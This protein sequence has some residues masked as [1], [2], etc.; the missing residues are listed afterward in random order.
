MEHIRNQQQ[1]QQAHL[2]PP[3]ILLQQ[4][5]QLHQM[6]LLQ[7][8]QMQAQMAAAAAAGMAD[9]RFMRPRHPSSGGA[10]GGPLFGPPVGA[11]A[12]SRGP[13]PTTI[14]SS[15]LMGG[16]PPMPPMPPHMPPAGHG[17]PGTPS[18]ATGGL[19]RFFRYVLRLTGSSH[20]C[21]DQFFQEIS[22]KYLFIFLCS[23]EVL[24]QANAG[25]APHMPPLPT[26][27]VLTLEEIE[28]QAAAVRI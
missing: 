26:Q 8:Q 5:Q 13:S 1:Q 17:M 16:M 20:T 21:I 22:S 19:S 11:G 28:R 15:G 18:G 9:P 10:G 23:P 25:N 2:P 14:L 27:K 7:A 3:H 12:G 6:K 4:Q 24:A